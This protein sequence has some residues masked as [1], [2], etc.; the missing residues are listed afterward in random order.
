MAWTPTEVQGPSTNVVLVQVFDDGVPSQSGTNEFVLVVQE[1]NLPPALAEIPDLAVGV[2]ELLTV[3]LV[4]TDDDLPANALTYGLVEGPP[5]M[6]VSPAGVLTWTPS[7]AQGSSTN[8]VRVRV[9]DDRDPALEATRQFTVVVTESNTAPIFAP[10]LRQTVEE[11][12]QWTLT[13]AATDGDLP[14]QGLSYALVSGPS[15]LTVS[16]LGEMTWT[17]TEAQGPSTNVVR[18][19]VF[20]DGTPSRSGTN[21]FVLV[22]QEVNLPPVLA[23]VPDLAVGVLEL[24]TVTLVGSDMD[25]PANVLTY[26]LVEGPSGLLVSTGGVVTWTP[27]DPQGPSTN[28]VRVKVADNR[29]P[30][31]EAIRQFTVTVTMTNSV[32]Q[33][34]PVADQIVDEATTLNFN[35]TAMDRDQPASSLIFSKVDGLAALTISPSG[36]VTWTPAE[37]DGP[38]T[39]VIAF[40]VTDTGIPALSATNSFAVIVRE[41]NTAPTLAAAPTQNIAMGSSAILYLA[42]SDVDRPRNQLTLELI[43]GPVGTVL[44]PGGLVTWTPL[45]SQTPSTNLIVVAVSDDGIPSLRS[46]NQFT[47]IGSR[48]IAQTLW[49]IGVDDL[50]TVLP[51]RPTFEFSIENGR[52][53][54]RPG[55]VTRLPGDPEYVAATN[56]MA[57]DDFYIAGTYPIGFNGLT[58]LLSVPFSEPALALERALT[59]VDRTNRVHFPLNESQSTSGSFQLSL[60]LVSGGSVIGSTVQPGFADHD[61]VIRFVNGAGA[62]TSLFSQ[63][64]SQA[65]NI[66]LNFTATSVNASTGGNTIE[67]V[68]TGPEGGGVFYW[69]Q[70]DYLRLQSD[71]GILVDG[72][73]DGLSTVWEADNYFSDGNAGD[74]ASDQDRDGLT[75][76]QEFN[77]GVNSTDPNKADTDGDGLSD[78]EE[79]SVGSNP[80]VVDTDDD[81]LSDLVEVRNGSS[82]LVVDSDGDGVSD[83]AER[84]LGTDPLDTAEKPTLFQGG[85]AFN[86]VSSSDFSGRLGSNRLAGVVPQTLWNETVSLTASGRP[87]GDTADLISPLPGQVVRSDG[88][89]LPGVKIQWTSDGASFNG[90]RGSGDQA[91]MNGMLRASAAV[92]AI[93]TVSNVPFAQYDVY[94]LVGGADDNFRGRVRLGADST[95]DRFF[96]SAST[97][98]Q[99]EFLEIGAGITEYRRGNLIRYTNLTQGT[100]TISLTNILGS[101]VGIHGLQIVDTQLDGD[102]SGIPDWWELKHG[103]GPGSALLAAADLDG[104]GLSNL[105]EYQRG[106]HP[107]NPDTDGDGLA[108]NQESGANSSLWDS[109][110]DTLSDYAE[111]NGEMPSNPNRIDT[112]NDGVADGQEVRYRSDPGFNETSSPSFIGWAPRYFGSPAR[113][114]WNLE[115]VQLLWDH[116]AGG[117]DV[118]QNLEDQLVTFAI[119]NGSTTESRTLVLALRYYKGRISYTFSSSSVGGFSAPSAPGTRLTDS[120]SGGRVAN[121]APD[122]GF[123]GFGPADISDRLQFRMVAE[124]TTGNSWNVTVEIRNQT[125]NEPLVVRSYL[126]CTAAASVDS[127]TAVWRDADGTQDRTILEPH[128]GVSL[129]FS[130]T[131]LESRPGFAAVRDS[132]DDGPPDL[133]ENAYGL[134]P[135]NPGDAVGDLDNDGVINRDEWLRGTDPRRPDSDGDR[136]S[137]G[138]EVANVSDPLNANSR[139]QYAGFVWP[140]G[141]DLDLNGL[142]DAWEIR[143]RAFNLP[144]SGDADGDGLSNAQEALWGTNPFDAQSR[145]A[146]TFTPLPPDVELS[147]PLQ[148][149]KKQTLFWKTGTEDWVEYSLPPLTIDGISRVL[150]PNRLELNPTELYRVD[151]Q[152][153]DFDGDGVSDWAEGILGSDPHRANSTRT[154]LR[155]INGAGSVGGA[156]SGDYVNFVEQFRNG[157]PTGTQKMSRTQAA[158]FLQQ[159]TFGP[160]RRDLDHLQ[161]LGFEA[162]LHEQIDV[163]P[164][165]LHLPYIQQIASDYYGVRKDFTYSANTLTE[166]LNGENVLTSF[167]RAA[168]EGPDQLRQRVAFAL[169]QILVI[170]RRDVNLVNSPQSVASYHDIFVRNAF[171]NYHDILREVTFHPAMG[172]YLSAVG[173]QKAIPEI[174]QYPD[175]NYAR[176]VQQLFTIGLWELNPDGTRILNPLGAP[177]ATYGN[178]EITEFARVF[179]GLWFGGQQWGLGGYHDHQL[180]VPMDMFADKHDFGSKTLLNGFVIPARSPSAANGLRDVEDALR[181]LVEHPN[182]APFI[183]TQLIQFLVTSNPSTQY[184]ARVSAVFA[185]DGTGRR[186][187][188]AAVVRAILLDPEARRAEWPTAEPGYGRLKEPVYRAMNLARVARLGRHTNLLWHSGSMYASSLQEP[189]LSPSVFNFFRPNFRPP[190]LLSEKGLNGPA[191]QILDS[192]SSISF[193]NKLWEITE[194]GFISSTYAFAPDYAELMLLADDAEMLLDEVNLLF[195]GGGMSAATRRSILEALEQVAPYDRLLRSQLAVYL[196]ATCPDGAVQR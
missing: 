147:W 108:D 124:R 171:G 132:D 22:V 128:Q 80:T 47:V 133:W 179:T 172:W 137:D 191:F 51:Y 189:L 135:L 175:E 162:W 196:A 5:G 83:L 31:L 156:V 63:R 71:Q 55:K 61:I 76:L 165:T 161:E 111:L 105:Q 149:L 126:N 42:A 85:I 50:P 166:F 118:D 144:L 153:Q 70:H 123:C 103:I 95:T 66:V 6:Q 46:T 163:L 98:P 58:N 96:V 145:L 181:S 93:L 142:P 72:D 43:S 178:R 92:P 32:P 174:N 183:G 159:S 115:N 59:P 28:V 35:L 114:E 97:P 18:V 25:L 176:E 24:L 81:G 9:S 139:P 185:N 20:D 36:R 134:D 64:I 57:D 131:P 136:V 164:P 52:N 60:E 91:V 121:L 19:Q 11:L 2:L 187:N 86:F 77:G 94:V 41:V 141:E 34:T 129:Y 143:Y 65:T 167:A 130:P 194:K 8:A 154:A 38:G 74:A 100:F 107:G 78:G 170:S 122:L 21:E 3:T 190:G 193:P 29:D 106:S 169:G 119:R 54:A 168:V 37:T 138:L 109:D 73:G 45:F 14:A 112:D 84:R 67:I 15:G 180:T 40:R 4:G 88:T 82:P 48:P 16:A 150:L 117:L 27:S 7:P 120:P 89:A 53:D 10:V 75:A 177:I 23:A 110:G 62:G 102:G 125:R 158:R 152:D 116:G 13:L 39:N 127:G 56:P 90:N 87:S 140:T 160:T 148:A 184:V 33:P 113:W 99:A 182:T 192:Y 101:A 186:G 44:Y 17:P 26:G 188:L 49:Q 173:N 195:C 68:R 69:V 30:A 151:T 157:A 79:R 146:L 1:V 155:V 104:D 12:T